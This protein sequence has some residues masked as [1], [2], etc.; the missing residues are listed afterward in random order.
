MFGIYNGLR[1]ADRH[2]GA[3]RPAPDPA[4]EKAI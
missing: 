4:G 2:A 1:S 3:L